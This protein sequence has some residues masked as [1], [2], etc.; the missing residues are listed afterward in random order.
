MINYGETNKKQMNMGSCT[1]NISSR[2]IRHG[3][4]LLF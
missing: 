4:A 2:N 1:G 3:T